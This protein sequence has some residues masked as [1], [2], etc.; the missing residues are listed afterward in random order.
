[1]REKKVAWGKIFRR[2]EQVLTSP[3]Y[4]LNEYLQEVKT[5]QGYSEKYIEHL[6]ATGEKIEEVE[7]AIALEIKT[8]EL[9]ELKRRQA[10]LEQG[11]KVL[12]EF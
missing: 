6:K 8:A 10:Y 11:A 1:L 7:V 9:V 5:K 3:D 12:K 4:A 2:K